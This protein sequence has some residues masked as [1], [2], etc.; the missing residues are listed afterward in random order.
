MKTWQIVFCII[1]FSTL[2]CKKK[3]DDNYRPEFIG[4]WYSKNDNTDKRI[5]FSISKDSHAD[6]S[7]YEG[8][9]NVDYAGIARA[10]DHH[11]KIGRIMNLKII[12]YPHQIDTTIEKHDLIDY[13]GSHKLANWKMVLN[14][15]FP[16]ILFRDQGKLEYYKVDY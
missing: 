1:L 12:E 16:L 10:S 11:L 6:Y 14:G 7:L 2:G 3:I 8:M 13:I 4:M 9:N 15:I 5:Y